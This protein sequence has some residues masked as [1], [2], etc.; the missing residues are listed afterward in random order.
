MRKLFL[1]ILIVFQVTFPLQ[2]AKNTAI[3][4][5]EA[6]NQIGILLNNPIMV[7]PANATPLGRN[8]FKTETD[9]HVFTDQVSFQQVA[10]VL[11]DLENQ[12]KIYNGKKS[13]LTASI[14]SRSTNETIVDFISISF[15]PFGIQFK[16]SYRSSVKIIIHTDTKIS[17][18]FAQLASDSSS[19]NDMKNFYS[20]Q[21][22][23]EVTIN[24]RKYTYI[25][26]Y[27]VSDVNAYI[28]PGAK[29]LLERE[30]EPANIEGMQMIINAAKNR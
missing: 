14:V 21:Y 4:T 16:T 23:E 17:I 12:D 2:F 1:F 26:I 7:F 13:T 10:D 27:T 25:K 9:I 24:G 5:P 3:L 30:A 6:I 11:L 19:N 20:T 8:W 22:A 18:E 29:S 15:G 28:L